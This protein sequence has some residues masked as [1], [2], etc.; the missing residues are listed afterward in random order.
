MA[1]AVIA[2]DKDLPE[3]PDRRYWEM[4]SSYLV[5]DISAPTGW[6]EEKSGRR[7]S[8][9]M[10]V[11]N[12]RHAVDQWRER[13]YPVSQPTKCAPSSRRQAGKLMIFLAN[14]SPNRKCHDRHE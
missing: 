13:G 12:L 8:M 10:L 3:V 2:Y 14:T 11:K 9:L 5:K 1:K 6:R 7:P 4:P